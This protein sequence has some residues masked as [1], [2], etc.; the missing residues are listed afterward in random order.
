MFHNNP[1]ELLKIL[2]VT[3][4]RNPQTVSYLLQF[5][6]AKRKD[7]KTANLENGIFFT[8]MTVLRK[9][10]GT[11]DVSLVEDY[12][13]FEFEHFLECIELGSEEKLRLLIVERAPEQ[14]DIIKSQ[15]FESKMID[16]VCNTLINSIRLVK[17]IKLEP[18]SIPITLQDA[19]T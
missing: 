6:K 14:K 2:F 19:M 3:V 13:R 7:I 5:G 17:K 9:H 16:A 15:C 4:S 8:P 1:D 11:Y 12:L 18:S 10:E